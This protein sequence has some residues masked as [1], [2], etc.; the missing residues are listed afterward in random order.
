MPWRHFRLLQKYAKSADH[1][2]SAIGTGSPCGPAAPMPSHR[3]PFPYS[4]FSCDFRSP[5]DSAASPHMGPSPY[6]IAVSPYNHTPDA[7]PHTFSADPP[8]NPQAP[9][10]P[11]PNPERPAFSAPQMSALRHPNRFP[12][13]AS[14][15]APAPPAWPRLCLRWY[16]RACAVSATA[17]FGSVH[18]HGAVATVRP[19]LHGTV[20]PARPWSYTNGTVPWPYAHGMPSLRSSRLRAHSRRDQRPVNSNLRARPTHSNSLRRRGGHG[21]G[22]ASRC[23]DDVDVMGG[24][25][26][27]ARLKAGMYG[28]PEGVQLWP[29]SSGLVRLNDG[30][31]EG[32]LLRVRLYSLSSNGLPT[33]GH[34]SHPATYGL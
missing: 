22:V 26:Q 16:G 8:Y 31:P 9:K 30:P 7:F 6:G 3:L 5:C 4:G 14:G 21:Y 32:G 12:E 2:K 19:Y 15:V 23:D 28:T 13:P 1:A 24:G 10:N 29:A 33:N 17:V 20:V 25:G 27:T 11:T 34:C 18:V